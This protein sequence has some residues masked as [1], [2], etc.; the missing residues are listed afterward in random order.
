MKLK[1]KLKLSFVFPLLWDV[2]LKIEI[3]L[4]MNDFLCSSIFTD[5][6]FALLILFFFVIH[7]CLF[8]FSGVSF[9]FQCYYPLGD[10]VVAPRPRSR[11]SFPRVC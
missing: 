1:L 2:D 9:V 7:F 3:A 10:S 11:Q 4:C 8:L 6:P 5:I